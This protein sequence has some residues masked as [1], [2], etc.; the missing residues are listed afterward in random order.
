MSLVGAL[1]IGRSGLVVNQAALQVVGNNMANASTVGYSRQSAIGV[2][3]PDVQVGPNTFIGT[4]TRLAQ[5]VRH[6]DQALISRIRAS[7]ADQESATA[8]QELLTQIESIY[9]DLTDQG[10]T[11]RLTDFFNVWSDLAGN[12]TDSGLQSLVVAEGDSLAE[13]INGLHGDMVAMRNQ[14]DASIASAVTTADDLMSRIA[15]LN[16]QIVITDRGT[17]AAHGLRDERDRLIDELSK[18]IDITTVEQPSGT[19]DVFVKS[20]PVVLNGESRGL[21]LQTETVDDQLRL[22]VRITDDG[23]LIEPESGKLG[24]LLAAREQDVQHAMDK[25]DEMVGCLA[26]ELNV[27]HAS[28][29]AGRGFTSLT[30]TG[31]VEDP[32]AA[33]N[34]ATAGLPF[35]V[36]NGTLQI[37]VTQKSTG[38]RVA[39]QVSVDLDGLGTDTSLNDL[40]AAIDAVANVSASVTADGRL[41][42]A[43]DGSDFEFSFSD[44]SS[45]VLAAMGLNGFFSG[46][47]ASELSMNEVLTADPSMLAVGLNHVAGD[48]RTALAI[49]A[50]ADAPQDSLNGLS[51]MQFWRRNMEEYAVRTEQANAEVAA[52]TLVTEGLAA[53]RQ[54]ISGVSIDEE[55][56]NMLSY[57]RA[58][59]GSARFITVVDELM[60]TMLSLVN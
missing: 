27:L 13:Y 39:T 24:M 26:Y 57:Q 8:R 3:G 51:M 54:S 20:L 5:I 2:A 59:Q 50:L 30:S 55:A 42:I 19:V 43:A 47:K 12:P 7:L 36:V 38:L 15:S 45:C 9:G 32:A 60:Q 52:T 23:S 10:L 17:G 29:Q 21:T 18:I 33:L 6:V 31:R 4:G 53:Q 22:S 46:S 28:G 56:I 1:Q 11:S 44:D 35:D 34:S 48:N 25:L 41:A 14:V 37:H 16:Q 40:A 58:F 49:A